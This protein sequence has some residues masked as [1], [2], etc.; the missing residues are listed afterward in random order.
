M[1]HKQKTP[2]VLFKMK[3]FSEC[4]MKRYVIY[5]GAILLMLSACN[6]V[7]HGK[8]I[9]NLLAKGVD[10]V[11]LDKSSVSTKK[12]LLELHYI[13]AGGMLIRKGAQAV[14]IDPFFTFGGSIVGTLF[15]N[16]KSDTGAVRTYFRSA[17]GKADDAEGNIKAVLVSHAHYDHIMDV[18]ALWKLKLLNQSQVHF[19]GSPTSIHYLRGASLPAKQMQEVIPDSATN[20]K[21]VGKSFSF[22]QLTDQPH[23][24]VHP[25]IN[26]HAPHTR[27]IGFPITFF[28]GK[29]KRDKWPKKRSRF[30]EGQNYS[31][32]IDFL[33]EQQNI[34]CRVL[35]QSSCSKPKKGFIPP[36][37]KDEHPIDVAVL[38]VASY[39]YVKPYPEDLIKYLKPRHVVMAHWEN[40]FRKL[41]QL[42]EKPQA[43]PKSDIKKFVKKVAQLMKAIK[44]KGQWTLP[45]VDTKLIFVLK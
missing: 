38:G 34:T 17:F 45:Q 33:D 29:A 31:Y 23:I 16:S 8:R 44:R 19:V 18:P 9:N 37:L 32:L 11:Y 10:T 39:K 27:F 3:R 13:G 25:I 22:G 28:K 7:R 2:I 35:V 1:I 5:W 6:G 12:Q 26:K 4:V 40:F 24:K 20:Y 36:S 41:D 30:K 43:V 21:K 42:K 14:L 15:K